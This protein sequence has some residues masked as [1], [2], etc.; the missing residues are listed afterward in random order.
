MT[1]EI[2]VLKFAAGTPVDPPDAEVPINVIN[3]KLRSVEQVDA[4]T[5]GANATAVASTSS[6]LRLTNVLLTSLDD[7]AGP[8]E[9][10]FLVV[11][12]D[13]GDAIDVNNALGI[14]TGTGLLLSLE[15]GASIWMLY[16]TS[17]ASWLIVG[18]S[19]GGGGTTTVEGTLGAPIVVDPAV[20]IVFS[21]RD[22]SNI[23]Y[24]TSNGGADVISANPQISA[25]EVDG[26]KLLLIFVSDVDTIELNDGTGL[27]LPMKFIS[28][29][30]RKQELCWNGSTWSENYRR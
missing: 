2:K 26:Q 30:K 20:G 19:G 21:G 12:N 11:I 10:Q 6:I 5:T 22:S 9:G 4:V 18:G 23:K 24:V 29:N 14:L 1:A 17:L 8:S 13:T 15:D 3:Q 25:G 16:L 7:V 27:D 28:E